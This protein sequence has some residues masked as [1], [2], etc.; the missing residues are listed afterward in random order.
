MAVLTPAKVTHG[1][2]E[3]DA[4]LEVW[5]DDLVLYDDLKQQGIDIDVGIRISVSKRQQVLWISG[6]YDFKIVGLQPADG[7]P[8][9]PFES[10]FRDDGN[11]AT[12]ARKVW[13]GR[14]Q[15]AADPGPGREFEYKTTI[16]LANGRLIDP[17]IITSP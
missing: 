1:R 6:T 7:G 15:A 5:I 4:V 17:H 10:E 8:E 13:S 2:D 9:R 11:R 3:V 16:L 14:P 12:F